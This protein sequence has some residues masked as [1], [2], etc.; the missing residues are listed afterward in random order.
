MPK[1]Y[2]SY[3][4]SRVKDPYEVQ[5]L[6]RSFKY[7]A[8]ESGET[9]RS[10]NEALRIKKSHCLE[11]CFIA[12]ALLEK[13]GFEPTVLSLE[14]V[15]GLDHVVYLFKFQG[16]WGSIGH[17]R[18]EGLFGRKAVFA[19]AKEVAKSYIDPYVDMSGRIKAYAICN[20]NDID[21]DW[22]YSKRN[23][24]VA[25]RYFCDYPHKN[26]NCSDRHYKKLLE[27]YKSGLRPEYQN[28]W[29]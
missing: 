17:S 5:K 10:A 13:R 16:R 20:L 12:A 23:V 11:A 7:N 29:L 25:E 19:S 27:R 8:E 1:D 9:L 15:D 14:S 26:L 2:I 28:Y 24:W 22:R 6:L 4:S 21:C 3:Y 18:D